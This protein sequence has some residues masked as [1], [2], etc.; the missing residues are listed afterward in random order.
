ML[1][2]GDIIGQHVEYGD[3]GQHDSVLL[4]RYVGPNPD[5]IDEEQRLAAIHEFDL[6]RA[7]RVMS[8]LLKE[9]PGH[10]WCVEHDLA[11]GICKISIPILMGI[12]YWYVLNLATH[13]DLTPGMVIVA[14]GE[15][16]ERYGLP[17]CRLEIGSFLDARAR[18]S[19]LVDRRRAVPS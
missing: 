8:V 17:R 5:H 6:W 14:G 16:L 7:R 19:A 9:Y 10:L 3:C 13:G 15:I 1:R 4:E 18:Y 12:G 2:D 11:Q